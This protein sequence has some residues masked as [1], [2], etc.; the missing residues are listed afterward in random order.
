M[1]CKVLSIYP[2]SSIANISVNEMKT[3]ITMGQHHQFEVLKHG[4]YWVDLLITSTQNSTDKLHSLS[5]TDC[6][7][8][9][10]MGDLLK[11]ELQQNWKTLQHHTLHSSWGD[12]SGRVSQQISKHLIY[13]DIIGGHR[14]GVKV[15]GHSI[16]L[17]RDANN[18]AGDIRTD[19]EKCKGLSGCD[20]QSQDTGRNLDK[21][22]FA[23]YVSF[24]VII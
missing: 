17:K 9:T 8:V 4:D 19:T 15:H 22:W 18:D 11:T 12:P 14:N 20:K 10:S 21:G 7:I 16:I 24:Y 1:I 23:Q 5:L 6:F 2:C 3:V 13:G